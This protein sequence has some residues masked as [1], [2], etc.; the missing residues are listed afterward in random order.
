MLQYPE[1]LIFLMMKSQEQ[2]LNEKNLQK[3]I[4]KEEK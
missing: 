4:K 3:K 2:K 1:L